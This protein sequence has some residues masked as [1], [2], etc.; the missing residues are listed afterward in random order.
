MK[1]DAREP[2]RPPGIGEP[3]GR[4]NRRLARQ[5]Q[6]RRRQ[7]AALGTLG[8]I[9]LVLVAV[10]SG[11]G[12][13]STQRLATPFADPGSHH[14]T[15]S[16]SRPSASA[17]TPQPNPA[18]PPP[19]STLAAP[20]DRVLSYTSYVRLAGHR[21][22]D[23]ALT[24]DDGPSPFTPQVLRVLSATHTPAT[25]FVIGRSA[26]LY[27]RFVTAEAQAGD[28]VGDHT[29]THPPLGQLAPSEQKSQL[30]EA[31]AAITAG[32][33]P[34]PVLMRP[35]YG[36]F[37]SATLGVLRGLR[38]LMVLWSVDTSDYAR[39]GVSRIAYTAISGAQPGAIILMH[40]GG[41]DRSETVAALPR[42][43]ARLRQRGFHLVTISQL[44]ADDPPPR[45]QPPPRPL[46]GF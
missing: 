20:V 17:H 34:A 33:A 13:S 36:S 35:P 40:D 4:Y 19:A 7:L 27:P 28:E 38:L 30:T 46:S 42:I 10:L 5:R 3:E 24:F 39:P 43:I 2:L 18:G 21:R 14:A 16:P 8:V 22:K 1:S 15:A 6:V 31:A 26:R 32:G 45:N 25:F 37:D 12:R 23:V 41:G 29:E 9:V 11:G 44:V